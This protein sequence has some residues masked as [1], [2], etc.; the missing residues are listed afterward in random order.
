VGPLSRAWKDKDLPRIHSIYRRSSINQ[1]IFAVGVFTLIWINFT[2]GVLTF[3]LKEGYL[4][5]KPV[6]LYIGLMRLIDLGT[7]LNAQ[8]ISTSVYWRFE[9]VTGLILLTLTLPMNYLL[10][11][12]NGI[13]GTAVSNLVAMGVYNLIRYIFLL[14]KFNM[15][16]F[17]RQSLYTLLLGAAGYFVC[18][19]LFDQYTGL[20]WLFVRSIVFLVIF[21]GGVILLN[22]SPDVKP[23]LQTVGKR[24]GFFKGE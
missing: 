1:L 19:M 11:Q 6:F 8:I 16:P 21:G 2:D 24:L 22:L 3:K 4:D 9:F 14:K 13:I 7:G 5:A 20:L 10:T 15:Q 23:V 18:D 12:S 17:T